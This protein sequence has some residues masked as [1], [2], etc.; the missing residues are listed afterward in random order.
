MSEK[1]QVKPRYGSKP[2]FAGKL[3][4]WSVTGFTKNWKEDAEAAKEADESKKELQHTIVI[5]HDVVVVFL[6]YL[7]I[8]KNNIFF[9]IVSGF[10]LSFAWYSF[11]C[12]TRVAIIVFSAR[13]QVLTPPSHNFV[14][15]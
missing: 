8:F 2:V 14:W 3:L 15:F 13:F 7:V 5:V 12:K 10:V 4:P 11:R 1:R 9:K 6:Y